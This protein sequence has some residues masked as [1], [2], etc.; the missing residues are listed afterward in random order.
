MAI[1]EFGTQKNLNCRYDVGPVTASGA[2]LEGIFDDL[3]SV[4]N[5]QNE[6]VGLEVPSALMLLFKFLSEE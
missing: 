4:S 6:K 3:H 2:A 1:S 5:L